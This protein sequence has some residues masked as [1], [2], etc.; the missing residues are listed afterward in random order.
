MVQSYLVSEED[1]KRLNA[2]GATI[3][4][5]VNLLQ[6]A[7]LADKNEQPGLVFDNDELIQVKKVFYHILTHSLT[8][9]FINVSYH[10]VGNYSSVFI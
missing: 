4:W 7:T 2:N 3:E 9:S 10:I 6:R 8:H 5:L 1:N